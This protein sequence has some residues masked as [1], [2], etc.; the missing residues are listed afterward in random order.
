MPTSRSHHAPA[1]V[2]A[3]TPDLPYLPPSPTCMDADRTVQS[4]PWPSIICY[5]EPREH[6]S[7]LCRLDP[8]DPIDLAIE[9]EPFNVF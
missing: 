8:F 1:A 7:N 2:L 4:S 3:P 6:R 9:H 5:W